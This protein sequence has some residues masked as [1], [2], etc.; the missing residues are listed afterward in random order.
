[1]PRD[2]DTE[3]WKSEIDH[4]SGWLVLIGFGLFIFAVVAY[5]HLAQTAKPGTLIPGL[6]VGSLLIVVG[7]WFRTIR[8]PLP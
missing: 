2:P 4:R 3:R 6:I 8:P 5:G 7:V 1:M